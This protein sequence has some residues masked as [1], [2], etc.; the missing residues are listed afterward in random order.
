MTAVT[1]VSRRSSSEKCPEGERKRRPRT[2]VHYMKNGVPIRAEQ[3]YHEEEG[4]SDPGGP[5]GYENAGVT[6]HWNPRGCMKGLTGTAA[7]FR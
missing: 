3:T 7:A 1:D 5:G 6:R 4:S 2:E